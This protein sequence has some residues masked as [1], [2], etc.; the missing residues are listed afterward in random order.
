MG[1]ERPDKLTFALQS[2]A[3]RTLVRGQSGLS[4]AAK[5]ATRIVAGL[6]QVIWSMVY[7]PEQGVQKTKLALGSVPRFCVK[8]MLN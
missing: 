6:P 2:E 7:W 4:P 3:A 1:A 8:S 5:R